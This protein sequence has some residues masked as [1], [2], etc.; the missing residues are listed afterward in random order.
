MTRDL[1]LVVMWVL[2]I[3]LGLGAGVAG[4]EFLVGEG[5]GRFTAQERGVAEEALMFARTGCTDHP[6]ERVTRRWMRVV[7]LKIQPGYCEQGLT[8]Y[9]AVIR[10]YT[11]FGV[12][13]G[14]ILVDSCIGTDCAA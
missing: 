4:P 11:L 10:T 8:K 2:G 13:T 6:I 12:P 7:D 14:T 1:R 9:Q 3:A 5:L